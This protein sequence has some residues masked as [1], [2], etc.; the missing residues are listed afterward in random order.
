MSNLHEEAEQWSDTTHTSVS[1]WVRN[2]DTKVF[3]L[4]SSREKKVDERWGV[5]DIANALNCGLS[6]S[7]S[8]GAPT[9]GYVAFPSEFKYSPNTGKSIVK[10]GPK[11]CTWLPVCGSEDL[12][13]GLLRGGC[14]TTYPLKL[15]GDVSLPR[16]PDLEL[17]LPGHGH[18]RFCVGAFGLSST[19]LFAL[20]SEQGEIYCWL[21]SLKE[22]AEL[23]P[24]PNAPYLGTR[25]FSQEVWSIDAKD[26]AKDTI[27]FWPSDCGLVA[28][29][30]DVLSLSYETRLLIEGCCLSVPRILKNS[31]YVL[32]EKPDGT[33]R[34]VSV[35]A[36]WQ[37]GE[38]PR[39]L[40]VNNIPVAKWVIAAATPREVI[41]LSNMGQVVLRPNAQQ[42]LFIPWEAGVE[43]QFQLGGPHCSADGHLWMQV[44]HPTLHDGDIGF[45]YVQLGFLNSE[46]R[47]RPSFCART[48]TGSGSIRVEK[49]L[50]D[51][52][53]IEPTVVSTMAHE[54]N[55]A[56]LPILESTSDN[57]LLVLR[58][59]HLQGVTQLFERTGEIIPT[60]FQIM[61]QH[62]DGGFYVKRLREPWT[63]SAFIFDGALFIYH[64]DIG[65]LP[66]W[67]TCS[68]AGD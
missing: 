7:P 14:L 67:L 29:K 31:V 55:E 60:R 50:K 11:V 9:S 64:S 36:G 8:D 25:S 44:L 58:V 59:D 34:A 65:S 32:I 4:I 13:S 53:W 28:I 37:S 21:P 61:G 3:S 10:K 51:D 16:D 1:V 24:P 19:F 2:P 47:T 30:I 39:E 18:Y 49:W 35:D 26:M 33:V 40:P 42:F 62:G 15:K 68:G 56:V 41:W 38:A 46:Q 22:W 57:T 43:P 63:T 5:L 45:G 27:L 6:N 23:S 17:P 66:G 48:L 12:K 54:N 52:P 20:E